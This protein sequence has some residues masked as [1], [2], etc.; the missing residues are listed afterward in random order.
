VRITFVLPEANLSGGVRVVAIHADLLRKAGHEVVVVSLPHPVIPWWIRARRFLRTGVWLRQPST[1]SHLDHVDVEHRILDEHRP[2]TDADVPDADVVV[3]TWWQTAEQVAAL[4]PC[5]GVKAYFVQHDETEFYA[6]EDLKSRRQVRATLRLP[7][8]KI[9]VSRWIVNRC[10]E[11]ALG[12]FAIVHNAVDHALFTSGP[13]E[14]QPVATVGAMYSDV[15]FK[16][17]EMALEAIR[18]AQRDYPELRVVLFGAE[19]LRKQVT[20]P[21]NTTFALRPEQTLLPRLYASCDAWLFPSRAEGF[22]LPVLE[23]MA[24]GTPV[25]GTPTGIAPEVVPDGGGVLLRGFG[26][27]E[28]AAA[29]LRFAGMEESEWRARSNAATAVASTYR[30]E[31]SG[32]AFE[33]ELF[34]TVQAARSPQAVVA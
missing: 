1:P 28:M 29:I 23:A 33:A 13:R 19:P 5:K 25:I 32:A 7:M 30:W 18:L 21:P 22:G 11:H 4:S 15:V 34:R 3:A 20:L 12:G 2:V 6:S 8:H 16:G 27:D 24:C 14:R 10:A 26:A 9:A 31:D 17:S